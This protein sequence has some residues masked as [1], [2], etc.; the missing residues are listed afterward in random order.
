MRWPKRAADVGVVAVA[1]VEVFLL[2]LR[3]LGADE[4]EVG[5]GSWLEP[6]LLRQAEPRWRELVAVRRAASSG[7]TSRTAARSDWA[8]EIPPQIAKKSSLVFIEAGAGE[9]SEPIGVDVL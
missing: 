9:W 1:V 8:P 6:P 4:H 7:A 3:R 2:Q 5:V